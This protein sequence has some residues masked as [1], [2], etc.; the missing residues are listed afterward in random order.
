MTRELVSLLSF[1]APYALK[2][3]RIRLRAPHTMAG[4]TLSFNEHSTSQDCSCKSDPLTASSMRDFL[5][6]L[7][8]AVTFAAS[9]TML[10]ETEQLLDLDLDQ[11]SM[12]SILTFRLSLSKPSKG[13]IHHRF[14]DNERKQ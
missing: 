11:F 1:H 12:L 13:K 5:L 6:K 7:R 10:T 9:R 2:S 4:R 14:N 3:E 8:Q